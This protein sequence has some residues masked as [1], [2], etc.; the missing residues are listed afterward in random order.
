MGDCWCLLWFWVALNLFAAGD[1]IREAIFN[2]YQS[3]VTVL[4][5][6]GF[7]RRDFETVREFE[8]AVRRALPIREEALVSLDG[9]VI[10]VL[11]GCIYMQG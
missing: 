10:A 8:A 1:E 4:Q 3:L 11:V 2:C 6:R 7:L 5:K 9:D